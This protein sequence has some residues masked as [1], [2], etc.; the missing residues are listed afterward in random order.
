MS[1][2]VICQGVPASGK[3]TFARELQRAEGYTRVNRDEI[4]FTL[5]GSY[6]GKG[7]D[8]EVVTRVENAAIE[9][10]LAA[11]RNVVL[12]ATNLRRK[13]ITPKLSI[14]SLY[15]AEVEFKQFPV[16]L[17]EAI[18]RDADRMAGGDRGVGEDV[19]RR[20]FKDFKLDPSGRALPKPP[21][22]L[23]DFEA[24]YPDHTTPPAFIVDTDG[25]M[26]NGEGL[27][28]PYDTHLYHVDLV[29]PHVQ[30]AVQALQFQ[31]YQI[32][33][34]SGRDSEFRDVSLKWWD[35]VAEITPDLF[36]MRPQGDK[37]MDAIVKYELFR[38]EIAPFYN[39]LGA[40]DDRPQVLRMWR[41]I[42]LPTITI[43]TGEEF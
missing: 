6:W 39:V 14:A 40:F 32:I 10:A 29:H 28:G 24:Y 36:L 9:G 13:F 31:G 23:P 16:S 26:A 18:R 33:A 37:R 25:T 41:K 19:I 7:V 20:I 43:G 27:R 8:E 35:D 3:S 42:G 22:P 34:L 38:D 17:D 5:Y 15:G 4:R 1:K 11:G 30:A 21:A 2:L 12:D